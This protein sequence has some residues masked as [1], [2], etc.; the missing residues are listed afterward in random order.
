MHKTDRLMQKKLEK[1]EAAYAEKTR[2]SCLFVWGTWESPLGVSTRHH[3]SKYIR[4]QLY[5]ITFLIFATLSFFTPPTP[6]A[7][8]DALNGASSKIQD[9]EI[10][11]DSA[12]VKM[13]PGIGLAL[14]LNPNERVSNFN[15]KISKISLPWKIEK[16]ST[17]VDL[18]V[19]TSQ[20]NHSYGGVCVY[21]END[22]RSNV[23]I[24]DDEMVG[25]FKIE[26][27]QE[28]PWLKDLADFTALNCTSG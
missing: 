4:H 20:G 27:I 1:S 3:A 14:I 7:P 13:P 10:W 28:R 26:K 22:H 17:L 18:A 21:L 24:C 11:V 15:E 6:A 25:H 12:Y 2:L 5:G 8:D 16:C 9:S 23:L 19:T